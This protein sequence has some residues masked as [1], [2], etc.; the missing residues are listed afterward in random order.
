MAL[1]R[2][3]ALMTDVSLA[4]MMAS[5]LANLMPTGVPKVGYLELH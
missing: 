4:E 1:K 5:K 3:M 2:L